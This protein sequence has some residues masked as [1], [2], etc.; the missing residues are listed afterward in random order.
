MECLQ[1]SSNMRKGHDFMSL[2]NFRNSSTFPIGA[3]PS[4]VKQASLGEVVGCC[5]TLGWRLGPGLTTKLV[6]TP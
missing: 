1:F 4:L 5:H 6:P 3:N 2:L